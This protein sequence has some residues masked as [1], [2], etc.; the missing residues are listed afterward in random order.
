M[1]LI[2]F[3]GFAGDIRSE[4][5]SLKGLL[6]TAKEDTNKVNHLVEL[7][8]GY[9]KINPDFGLIYGKEGLT[10]AEKLDFKKG[11]ASSYNNIGL[12]YANQGKYDLALENYFKSLK[13]RQE[14]GNQYG[15]A[16]SYNNIGLIYA[17][18]GKYDLAL[19]NYF[20]SLK[21]MQEI[22][23]QY[24][25]ASSYNNIGIIYE[26]QGKYD[27]ALENYFKFLKIMQEIGNQYGIAS[28]YINI[29]N[30]YI[31]FGK[32]GKAYTYLQK[33]LLISKEIGN[34]IQELHASN[35][36]GEYYYKKQLFSESVLYYQKGLNIAQET[37]NFEGKKNSH[38]GLLKALRIAGNYKKAIEHYDAYFELY[39]ST[40]K[41]ESQKQ[42]AN[43]SANFEVAQQKKELELQASQLKK[44][45]QKK[46]KN[47]ERKEI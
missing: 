4:I 45:L 36:L 16:S 28:S 42:I 29:G 37:D 30:L 21:I 7:C 47:K 39:D 23:N 10:L 12:I 22:G 24:G 31:E 38:E 19:E 32:F 15:I 34:P 35:N 44:L 20:K 13:I 14:I 26:E 33:A 5:D 6:A 40:N 43:L 1:I 8:R 46:M 2:H 27:L 17:N 25:I 3:N 11:I 41:V 9:K 18:Q